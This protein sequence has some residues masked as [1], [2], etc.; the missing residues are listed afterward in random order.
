[1]SNETDNQDEMRLC[2]ICRM[3][4]SVWAT[5][6]HHCGEELGRPRREEAKLTLKDLGGAEQTKYT[7]SGNVTGAL[8]SFRVEEVA[9]EVSRSQSKPVGFWSRLMGKKAPLVERKPTAEDESPELNEYSKNL[10]ASILDDMPGSTGGAGRGRNKAAS[11]NPAEQIFKIVGAL[12][13]VVLLYFGGSFAW[14]K[15]SA[16]IEAR[17]RPPVVHYVNKAPEM[18]AR[19]DRPIDVFEEAVKAVNINDNESNRD[20]VSQVRNLVLQDV[21]DL[22]AMNPWR[23]E[24]HDKAYAYIQRAVN[25]DNHPAVEAKFEEVNKEVAAYKFVL[26]SIDE[27]ATEATFRTNHPNFPAEVTVQRADRLMDRFIVQRISQHAVE[28]SDDKY[29]GRKLRIAPNEGVKSRY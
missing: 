3:K 15:V 10:A 22:L 20:I 26:K 27:T 17:N 9:A 4:V 25:I 21:D 5:K 12:V 16:Y 6:C 24:N 11:P 2:P 8:E 1:M 13:A 7:P 23:G 18:L 19:G 28:L 29:D 14:D